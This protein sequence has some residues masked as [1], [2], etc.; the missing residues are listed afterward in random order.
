MNKF[1]MEMDGSNNGQSIVMLVQKT[2]DIQ[3]G[4]TRLGTYDVPKF[5]D[6]TL[7]DVGN[8]WKIINDFPSDSFEVTFILAD[9]QLNESLL[10]SSLKVKDINFKNNCYQLKSGSGNQD[11]LEKYKMLN[12]NVK[13]KNKSYELEIVES[14]LREY[15]KNNEVINQLQR[16]KDQ[17]RY[18][19]VRTDDNELETRYLELMEKYKQA[20]KRLG[21]LRGSKLGKMQ[22]A[23]WNK[24]RGY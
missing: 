23:Y 18:T 6:L 1:F 12:I 2:G 22:V 7:I 17:L 3:T 4:L 16:E 13:Q 24:K 14:L 9:N 20:L 8:A 10:K 15:N 5:V 19:G 11:L 21:Q